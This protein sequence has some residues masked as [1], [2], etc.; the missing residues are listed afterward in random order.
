MP[1]PVVDGEVLYDRFGTHEEGDSLKLCFRTSLDC[2]VYILSIDGTGYAQPIFP[3]T[4]AG[5][6]N[7]VKA[8]QPYMFPDG[9]EWIPLDSHR[10]VEHLYFLASRTP[11]PDLDQALTTIAACVREEDSVRHQDRKEEL[12]QVQSAAPVSGGFDKT[13]TST[14]PGVENKQGEKFPVEAQIFANKTAAD[15][16][17]TRWFRH[18]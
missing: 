7:P 16:V 18:Q 8:N 14:V 12:A 2:W 9:N 6:T 13:R 1:F 15:I 5:F 3:S 10:G 11:R 17:V 4:F